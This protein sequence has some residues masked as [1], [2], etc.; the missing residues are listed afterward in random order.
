MQAF[1]RGSDPSESSRMGFLTADLIFLFV[2]YLNGLVTSLSDLAGLTRA[3]DHTVPR[4]RWLY[5]LCGIMTVGGQ[6]WGLG[7]ELG[8][9]GVG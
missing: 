7:L 1:D 2:L 9:G 3:S 6:G 5:I 8:L 4:G